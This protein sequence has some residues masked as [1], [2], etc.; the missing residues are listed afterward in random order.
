M[1]V[2]K[3]LRLNRFKPQPVLTPRQLFEKFGQSEPVVKSNQTAEDITSVVPFGARKT[4]VL[5][6]ANDMA[7]KAQEFIDDPRNTNPLPQ[8]KVDE[9]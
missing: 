8:R 2:I 1:F 9:L 7:V 3:K 6:L 4:Q 5:Q